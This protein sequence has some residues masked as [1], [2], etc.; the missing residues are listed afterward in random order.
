MSAIIGLKKL[1]GGGGGGGGDSH[2]QVV[3]AGGEHHGGGWGRSVEAEV[4][5]DLAYRAFKPMPIS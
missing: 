2:P 4:A 1:V 5:H 3:Y